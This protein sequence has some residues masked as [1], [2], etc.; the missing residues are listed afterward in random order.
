MHKI[1]KILSLII[2]PKALIRYI[3]MRIVCQDFSKMNNNKPKYKIDQ[4][5]L[6]NK[7]NKVIYTCITGGYDLLVQQQ[8]YNK[9]YDYICFTDN[10]EWIEQKL[11]GIW[12]IRPLQEDK[13]G[14][15]LNNRWHKAHPHLLFSDY[16]Q[17]IY[18]DGNINILS[19]KVFKLIKAKKSPIV[20][21]L[22]FE[23]N[24]IYQE[25][26]KL[27]NSKKINKEQLLC[28]EEFLKKENF[29]KEYGLNENN[30]IYRQ[31]NNPQIISMMEM[32]WNFILN[33]AP[34]DQLSMS[35]VLYKNNIKPLDISIKNTKFQPRHFR[36]YS[37]RH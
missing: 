25:I 37:G 3:S 22:H 11:I 35:Y 10:K 16:E 14:L 20:I 12:Q 5:Q 31:H 23:R 29:P 17:S 28:I 26:I 21:P 18:I 1:K 7:K 8:Y 2:N 9:E 27:Q 36:V 34:R 19:D 33:F 30:L 32:W 13:F 15:A 4:N 6:L 24:C